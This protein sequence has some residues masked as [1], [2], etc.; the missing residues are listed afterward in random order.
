M[1]IRPRPRPRGGRSISAS[2]G[3]R[4]RVAGNTQGFVVF[5]ALV[6][7]VVVVV[8]AVLLGKVVRYEY[9]DTHPARFEDR[10]LRHVAEPAE[11]RDGERVAARLAPGD[12]VWTHSMENGDVVVFRGREG[13]AVLGFAPASSLSPVGQA[14]AR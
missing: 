7:V 2:F 5:G 12:S 8:A 11:V 4:G 1:A 6:L 10:R 3:R 13:D 9:P 14:R